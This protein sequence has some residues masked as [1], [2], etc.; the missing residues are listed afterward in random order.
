MV[1][2]QKKKIIKDYKN[3]KI[4]KGKIL[5]FTQFEQLINYPD[6]KTD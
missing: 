1:I 3:R 4:I 2:S 5:K 6:F